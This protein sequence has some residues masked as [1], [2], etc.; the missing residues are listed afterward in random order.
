MIF[1]KFT[2]AHSAG[3]MLPNGQKKHTGFPLLSERE[4]KKFPT[5]S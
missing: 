5:H 1:K 4:E 3:N 2:F